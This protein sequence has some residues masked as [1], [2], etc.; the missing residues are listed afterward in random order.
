[1]TA[2]QTFI[3]I[4]VLI[5]LPLQFAGGR[6]RNR[7][8]AVPA[9]IQSYLN[10]NYSGWRQ[11]ATANNC[12][13]EFK[14]AIVFGD[15]DGDGRRDFVVKFLHNRKGYILAFLARGAAYQPYVLLD[16]TAGELNT[17]GLTIARKGEKPGNARLPHD[18][19]VVGT[20]ESEACPYVYRNGRF[21]CD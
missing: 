2:R 18:A 21:S 4:F 15:F 6:Q 19:P 16:T 1:M 8:P 5:L 12:F 3:S 14:R 10:E 17:T 7:G 11:S 13:A 20:C 9:K